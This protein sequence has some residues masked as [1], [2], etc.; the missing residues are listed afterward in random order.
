MDSVSFDLKSVNSKYIDFSMELRKQRERFD[1]LCEEVQTLKNDIYDYYN[2]MLEIG[3]GF[4][5][6][7]SLQNSNLSQDVIGCINYMFVKV[8]EHTG[9]KIEDII[10]NSRG[11]GKE[12]LSLSRVRFL[13]SWIMRNEYGLKPAAISNIL[14]KDR[15]TIKYYLEQ[16]DFVMAHTE[17]DSNREIIELVEKIRG[18]K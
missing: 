18:E 17:I 3:L 16:M 13:V 12:A 14:N 8:H 7:H 1:Y 2:L 6:L 11:Q 5:L 4:D 15:N 10:G 9:F